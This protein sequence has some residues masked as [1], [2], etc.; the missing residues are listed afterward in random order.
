MNYTKIIIASA[1]VLCC[2]LGV[3]A[4]A[5]C[6]EEPVNTTPISR[7]GV[8][9][10]CTNSN[11][12]IEGLQ[13]AAGLCSNGSVGSACTLTDQCGAGLRCTGDDASIGVCT[14]GYRRGKCV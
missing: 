1:I 9:G 12:C 13:C 14:D 2:A 11:Q 8:G 10:T 4:I 3:L 5:A 7:S 6:D